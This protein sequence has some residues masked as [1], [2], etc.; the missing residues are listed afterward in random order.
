MIQHINHLNTR[1]RTENWVEINDESKRKYDNN[2]IRFKTSMMRSNLCDF[3]DACILV[4]G[5]IAFPNMTAAGASVNNTNKKVI[6]KNCVPFTDCITKINNT[7]ID[8][9]PDINTVMPMYNLIEYSDPYLKA[10]RS[11]WQYNRDEPALNSNSEVIHF[12]ANNNNSASLKFKQKITGQKGSSVAK[13]VKIMVSLKY[14]S[15]FSGT[16]QMSQTNC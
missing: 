3:S 16:L 13:D 14:L 10:S 9:A 1:F 15:D 11:L 12:P 4:K 8:D 5:T 6:L 2:N 7:Q